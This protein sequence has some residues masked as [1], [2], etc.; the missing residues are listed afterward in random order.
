[1]TRAHQTRT[2]DGRIPG[3]S[4]CDGKHRFRLP[5]ALSREKLIRVGP[6]NADLEVRAVRNQF[7][8]KPDVVRNC[9]LGTDVC[10]RPRRTGDDLAEAD[11]AAAI[12]IDGNG[13]R[14]GGCE[15]GAAGEDR[16]GAGLP[17]ADGHFNDVVSRDRFTEPGGSCGNS[18]I[19]AP[20]RIFERRVRKCPAEF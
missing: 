18:I 15:I 9:L 4:P 5:G 7:N 1:M 16:S 13:V 10:V 2:P 6:L 12:H 17:G 11:G 14:L 3:R 20:E 8:A 19:F